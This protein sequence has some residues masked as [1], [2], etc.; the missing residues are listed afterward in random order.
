MEKHI[1][2]CKTL[3]FGVFAVIYDV[4]RCWG[5]CAVRGERTGDCLLFWVQFSHPSCSFGAPVGHFLND[6]IIVQ[7]MELMTLDLAHLTVIDKSYK[8]LNSLFL[9]NKEGTLMISFWKSMPFPSLASLYFVYISHQ[10]TFTWIPLPLNRFQATGW[11]WPLALWNWQWNLGIPE[12]H[13]TLK[14]ISSALYFAVMETESR[15]QW[16]N[17]TQVTQL[18]SGRDQIRTQDS[19][20][21]IQLSFYSNFSYCH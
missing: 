20:F 13:W 8:L 6:R 21:W 18:L 15:R 17:L 1:S 3:G 14:I 12:L 5:C 19:W 16:M 10:H 2:F 9:Y 7:S 4:C 11:T